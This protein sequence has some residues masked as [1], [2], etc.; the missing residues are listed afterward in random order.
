MKRR[1]QAQELL[2]QIPATDTKAMCEK[3]HDRFVRRHRRSYPKAAEALLR[4]GDLM[5]T[6]YEFPMEHMPHPR[7]STVVES[8]LASVRLRTVARKRYKKV[9]SATVLIWK[10]L[11]IATNR[12][13]HLNAAHL[14]GEIAEGAEYS[15]GIRVHKANRRVAA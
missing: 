8:P 2:P 7:T 3:Q 6:F 11:M 13:R 12:F 15:D 10:I 1:S 9:V 14:L 5:V 4:D